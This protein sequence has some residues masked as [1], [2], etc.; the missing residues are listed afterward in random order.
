MTRSPLCDLFPVVTSCASDELALNAFYLLDATALLLSFTECSFALK[1]TI[2]KANELFFGEVSSEEFKILACVGN[3]Q[4]LLG[5]SLRSFLKLFG[6]LSQI[7][8]IFLQ[9]V[10]PCHKSHLEGHWGRGSS[11]FLTPSR[12]G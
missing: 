7:C 8:R 12:Q 10:A 4:L 3:L 6:P 11:L 2:E 1:Q 9:I 5:Q